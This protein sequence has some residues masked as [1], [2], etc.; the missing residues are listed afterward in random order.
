[1]KASIAINGIVEH[2]LQVGSKIIVEESEPEHR[3]N[4]TIDFSSARLNNLPNSLTYVINN[5][6][7]KTPEGIIN[8]P[9]AGWLS[10]ELDEDKFLEELFLEVDSDISKVLDIS[11]Q[12]PPQKVNFD[13]SNSVSINSSYTVNVSYSD[14]N[15]NNKGIS[16]QQNYSEFIPSLELKQFLRS[17][18]WNSV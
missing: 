9:N 15:G 14:L 2:I 7:V 12:I 4:V 6:K 5:L 13:G 16:L 1:M 18:N 3:F 11:L 8:V 17:Q 10:L